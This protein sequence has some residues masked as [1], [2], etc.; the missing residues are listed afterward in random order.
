MKQL[1]IGII[2][3][4]DSGKTTL[5][6]AL[7]YLSG[8]IRSFGRVD[9]GASFLD[10]NEMER[11][12]GITIFSKQARFQ[13]KDTSF[14]LIDT[15]GHADF[16]AETERTLK[17]L[18]YAILLIGADDGIKGQTK[19]LWKLL[20]EYQVPTIIFFNKMD[21]DGAD[22]TA[23]LA[24]IK[25]L[26]GDG[27][28]DFSLLS[29]DH[30]D[31]GTDIHQNENDPSSGDTAPQAPSRIG[32]TLAEERSEIY[33]QIA[34]CDEAAMEE[35]L[36]SDAL[37]DQTIQNLITERKLFPCLFGSA[38]KQEGVD[39]LLDLLNT[40]TQEKSYP[41]DFSA[42]VYK[43]ARDTDGVRLTYVKI[44]GG[45]LKTK[46]LLPDGNKES[47]INQLRFYSGDKY[48][49]KEEAKAG[50]IC[51]L[52]GL[53]ES[54]VG[55]EFFV[56]TAEDTEGSAA[57]SA[58]G[59][60]RKTGQKICVRESSSALLSPVLSYRVITDRENDPVKILP[61]FKTLEEE[62][63]ELSVYWDEDKR[64]IYV[65]V[66]GR[67]QLEILTTILKERF[68]LDIGFDSGSVVYKETITDPVI[69]VGHFE[70]LRHY[71]EVHLLLEP[72]ERGSGLSFAANV[73]S[74]KLAKN[75]QRLILT[76]L[77]ERRHRGVLTGSEITDMKITLIN[78]KAHLKHTE[79]GDF[80]QATYRAVRQG[81]MMA[82]SLL[83]E[84]FYRFTL[85]IPT[86]NVGKALTD[87][88]QM[89]AEFSA[90]ELDP[91]KDISIINGRGPV[92]ALKDYPA[93]IASY[94]KGLGSISFLPDGYGDCHNA[95]EVIEARGYDPE[96]DRRNTADSVFCQG[97]SG[98]IVPYDEVYDYMHLAFDG[99]DNRAEDIPL[100]SRESA[101]DARTVSKTSLG[102]DE[103]D[104]ILNAVS[105]STARSKTKRH[106][107]KGFGAEEE[108]GTA[109]QVEG[110]SVKITGIR[111]GGA[112]KGMKGSPQTD[113]K[114]KIASAFPLEEADVVLVDGYNVIFSWEELKALAGDNID[115][116]RDAL[117]QE[118]TNFCSMIEG[119]VI[120]VF[121]AYR[122]KGRPGTF[123]D[124]Q[125]IKLVY[126]AEEQTADQFIERF[127]NMA[128]SG[129]KNSSDV[130][131]HIPET[132]KTSLKKKDEKLKIAVVTSDATEQVVAMG[133][134]C[135]LISSG[136]FKQRY[137]DM[138][139]Q[140]ND[141]YRIS[142]G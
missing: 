100:T 69:G 94:T 88:D 127:V 122:V 54:Y 26:A 16:S 21:R 7:L 101:A 29:T 53:K 64:D 49:L 137:E 17:V 98:F 39:R 110:K 141:K 121:D 50:D 27:A 14:V 42:H 139:R 71:A 87:L 2:A 80:R 3:H 132:I 37:S 118:L 135:K 76:H 112:S 62:S 48:E 107:R 63:P 96:T 57:D 46:S 59:T 47:K 138:K 97:G 11:K 91:A 77:E 111:S 28:V 65:S 40:Y 30:S 128:G 60:S 136:D 51:I 95:E 103:V 78:G 20:S 116:A 33:E 36:S 123:S 126:T 55:E 4:V 12:R 15:P 81:L 10:N 43:V 114:K 38:L 68:D 24:D 115:A 142:D 19:I 52:T 124:F 66:M 61:I 89:K 23:L 90:P 93:E 109:Y 35:F 92:S 105:N 99:S 85:E 108:S 18:D 84:P 83:L 74:D 140:M 117:I 72:A 70:P 125:N 82:D 8:S 34:M 75:W 25:E 6:E 104:A 9:K 106:R 130:N 5:S 67:V 13:Y 45:S 102:T 41:G 131:V 44:T 120:A 58:A 31:A 22:K 129:F 79:G 113:P 73:S 119:D 32:H 134:G 86:A 1:T 56:E 133:Q